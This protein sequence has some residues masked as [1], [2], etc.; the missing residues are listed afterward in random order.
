MVGPYTLQCSG[1][2]AEFCNCPSHFLTIS[3][4]VTVNGVI[5]HATVP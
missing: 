1:I 4:G 3:S 5:T 2:I